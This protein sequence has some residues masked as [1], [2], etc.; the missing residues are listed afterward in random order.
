MKK[1]I[2]LSILTFGCFT[3]T[4]SQEY[5]WTDISDNNLG[6]HFFTDVHAIN[7]EVWLT[8][9]TDDIYYS[10]NGGAS[11]TTQNIGASTFTIFMKNTE[12]GYAGDSWGKV[13]RTT[14]GGN[15]WTPL[16]GTLLNT[17]Y[18][19]SF[20][21]V[22]NGYCCGN[23]GWVGT[24]DTTGIISTELLSPGNTPLYSISFPSTQDEGWVC[25]AFAFFMHFTNNVWEF[26]TIGGGGRSSVYFVSNTTEGWIVG[27]GGLI[28]HTSDG[29]TW[30]PQ[31]NPDTMDYHLGDVFSTD[32]Q[33]AW[34]VGP[35]SRILH[36]TDGGE[37]WILTDAGL[38]TENLNAVF[39]TSPTNGYAVGNNGKILKYTQISGIGELYQGISFDI[40]P[41]PVT[42]KIEIQCSEFKTES[43]IIEI[44]SLNGKKILE[45][46]IKTGIENI[47]LDLNNLNSGMYL[48]KITIDNRSSTKKIIK[49]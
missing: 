16:N 2:L 49:E 9:L 19:I 48:C 47:E 29:I 25:G 32:G 28:D 4:V 46:E 37:K 8:S 6:N 12:E 17:I 36:T 45:K 39:F 31:N 3:I 26:V 24:V 14:D 30:Y 23:N 44:L 18:S 7:E 10:D 27:D 43:G 15:T 11:F 13:H 5:G 40:Y 1:F 21:A 22:G 20:P 34:A 35:G 42:D 41:N 38:A 33:H